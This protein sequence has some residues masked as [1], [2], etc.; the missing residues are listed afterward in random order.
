MLRT[1]ARSLS[2]NLR[3]Q[4]YV[5]RLCW[6]FTHIR[7]R[8]FRDKDVCEV[9]LVLDKWTRQTAGI[10]AQAAASV[11][12]SNFCRLRKLASA[13]GGEVRGWR[14]ILRRRNQRQLR[15]LFVRRTR[16]MSLRALAA[17]TRAL[18]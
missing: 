4:L 8:H 14:C 3:A 9:D 17:T 7:F 11:S 2:I 16:S 5:S 10:E 13:A 12:S 18:G 6:D 1:A 15:Q